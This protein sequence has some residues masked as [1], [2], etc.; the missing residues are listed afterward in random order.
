MMLTKI[1]TDRQ[2]YGERSGK[3]RLASQ[4]DESHLPEFN[5]RLLFFYRKFFRVSSIQIR[6]VFNKIHKSALGGALFK[7]GVELPR[8]R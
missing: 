4:N 7:N 2:K 1:L 6:Y 8:I 5:P 3:T